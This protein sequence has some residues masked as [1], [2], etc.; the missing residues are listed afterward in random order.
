[1][2]ALG[3]RL[4]APSG[5]KLTLTDGE[6]GKSLNVAE[7]VH[8]ELILSEVDAV[9]GTERVLGLLPVGVGKEEESLVALSLPW[10][11]EVVL[12]DGCSDLA[13]E[14]EKTVD[15]TLLLGLVNRRDVVDNENILKALLCVDGK[16]NVSCDSI[17]NPTF[18]RYRQ[19]PRRARPGYLSSPP[20]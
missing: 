10:H 14:L 7:T 11:A 9:E 4:L 16:P 13:E 3:V 12:L 1:M 17:P 2:L 8:V 20:R 6:V 5:R 18:A 19:S 15:K